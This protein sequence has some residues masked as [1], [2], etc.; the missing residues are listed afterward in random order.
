MFHTSSDPILTSIPVHTIDN[1]SSSVSTIELENLIG[2]MRESTDTVDTYSDG[3]DSFY[4]S[5]ET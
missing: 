4:F 2:R 5:I 1:I 3:P